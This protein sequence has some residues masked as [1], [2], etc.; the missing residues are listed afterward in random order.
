M[1]PQLKR[2]LGLVLIIVSIVSLIISA[3]GVIALWGMRP[4]ITI[5]LQ[6]TVKLVSETVVT[7]QK[8]LA[9]ADSALQNATDT[10]QVLSGSID[11][12]ATSIGSTQSAL[13]SVTMLVKQDLP[14]TI[15][16]ARTALAS[17]QETARV[18]DNFLSGLS[19]IQFLNINYNP[20]VP[21]DSSISQISASLGG[22][23][24]QLTKLGGDLEAVNQN[25]PAVIST[26][27]GLGTTLSDVDATLAEARAVIK[28]YAAQ[29]TRT[30]TAVQ[31]IGEGI[32]TYVTLFIATLTFIML[33]ISVVQIIVL[34]VGWRWL[35]P[36]QRIA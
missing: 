36:N 22:L 24:S 5:A 6:D 21:L 20:D 27:R 13:N 35:R 33:W 12:L 19:R 31:P 17:A 23:P 1:N 30:Q 8:A 25:L 16:S 9:V 29:L 10:I 15:E 26:I 34:I 28:E 7:T 32:P 14:E 2:I 11:S 18:V 3:A 4:A